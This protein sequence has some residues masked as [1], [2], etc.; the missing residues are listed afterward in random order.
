MTPQVSESKPVLRARIADALDHTT[1]DLL[2][3]DVGLAANL[4][5]HDDG[6]GGDQRLA[7]AAD[8][9]EF[10]G[11]T[12]VVDVALALELGLLSQNGIEYRIGDLIGD[13][14][15]MA[16]GHG[17]RREHV[18]TGFLGGTKL[19]WHYAPFDD[20]PGDR[21]HSAGPKASGYCIPLRTLCGPQNG[22]TRSSV[23]VPIR[24]LQE[25][26]Y[27]SGKAAG[28]ACAAKTG[29]RFAHFE[30]LLPLNNSKSH[31]CPKRFPKDELRRSTVPYCALACGACMPKRALGAYL[32]L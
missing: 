32:H 8:I 3:V 19:I 24:Q 1:R 23:V 22:N 30:D 18:G 7:G 28:P 31:K 4:T 27:R 25:E 21:Y 5:G 20:T 9:F 26:A 15:G 29:K 14:V 6:A 17:L 11:N 12:L 13:L 10:S 16:L 2:H